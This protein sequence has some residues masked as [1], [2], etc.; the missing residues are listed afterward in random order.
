MVSDLVNVRMYSLPSQNYRIEFYQQE[1]MCVGKPTL[2]IYPHSDGIHYCYDGQVNK[3]E[4]LRSSL[5]TPSYRIVNVG[6]SDLIPLLD[7]I[8]MSISAKWGRICCTYV[9]LS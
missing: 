5:L 9:K 8:G 6:D 4:E 3:N 7:K 1:R 2:V